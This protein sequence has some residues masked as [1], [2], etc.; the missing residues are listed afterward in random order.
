MKVS[1]G[2]S[3]RLLPTGTLQVGA[4]LMVFGG[5]AYVQLAVAGHSLSTRGMAAMSV[6]WS[7][8]FLL[9]LGLFF[10]VEQELIRHVADRVAAGEGVLPVVRR[11]AILT[12]GILLLTLVPLAAAA[13]P[14]A[15]E[16]FDG[17]L[18]MVAALGTAFVALA[19]VSV[20]HGVL[21]GS[22]R[23][24]AYGGQL[25]IDGGL[26]IA[27]AVGL[28][29][30]GV[31][32]PLLFALILTAAPLTAVIATC[33][34]VLSELHPGP[35]ITWK[36]MCRGLALLIASTLLAQL[37]VNIGVV[38]AKLLSPANAAVVSAL[39]SAIILARVP[40]FIFASLQ[41]SLLPG[42][43]GAIAVGERSLFRRLVI[44][45]VIVVGVLGLAGGLIAVIIGP[46]LVEVM[47]NAHRIL[48]P[49]DFGWLAAGTLFYMLAMVLGQGAMALSRHR[50]QLLAWIAGTAVL[51]AITAI[52]GEVKLRVEAAY[53]LSSVTVALTL[54]FL[55]FRLSRRGGTSAPA[56]NPV[57]VTLRGGSSQ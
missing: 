8:V 13:R 35:T 16:L 50:D 46:W 4:G 5:A 33:R 43:A 55:L 6:L 47:F 32:S 20:S 29:V 18:G 23:F 26:R 9:G 48:G 34:P 25:A 39:L 38:N 24:G 7:V 41:A 45:A 54:A 17:D 28:G 14:L 56:S 37:I 11:A 10:P 53:A 3:L 57:A 36:L 44:R 30:A 12:G 22:G 31:H 15:D 2:K 52:P 1:L 21:A 40:L 49:A 42:L 19:V 27:C 51:I